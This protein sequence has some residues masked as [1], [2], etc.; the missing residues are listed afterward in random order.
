LVFIGLNVPGY[1]LPFSPCVEIGWRLAYDHWGKGYASEGAR[2]ALIFG[3]EKMGLAEIVS[4]TTEKNIRSRRAI[5][6]VGMSRDIKGDF[7]RPNLPK[8][9]PLSKHVLYRKVNRPS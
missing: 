2:G 4:F 9:H 8:D 1:R 3:F 7:N 6:K 5:E